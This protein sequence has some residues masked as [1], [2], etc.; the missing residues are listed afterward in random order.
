MPEVT[1]RTLLAF[2]AVASVVE[3][4]F[5]EGEGASPELRALIGAHEA[6]YVGLHRV[7]HQ[8]GSSSCERERADRIEQKALLAICSYPATSRGDRRAKADYLLTA[9]TRG[10]LDL[11]EH[12]QAILHSMKR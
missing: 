4:T 3:P 11:E 2:A 10:E 1:R 7:V 5:A 9:E 6:S 8:A 12:M